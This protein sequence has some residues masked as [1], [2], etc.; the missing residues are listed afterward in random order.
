MD[1]QHLALLVAAG[2]GAG[3]CNALAGGGSLLT[4]PALLA[5]GMPPVAATVTNAVSVW[6]GYI[7]NA[8]ALR[9]HLTSFRPLLPRL[10]A[11]A[12]G[13]AVT[14]TV[15]LL[16]A[17]P[18]V[19][20]A[21]VPFLILSATALFACQPLITRR[22]AAS[23]GTS[24]PLL[25][26]GVFVGG[27]YGAYFN[28]GMGIVFLTALALGL[29]AAIGRLNGL[30]ALLTLT[31]GTTAM[32]SVALFGPVQWPAVLVLAPACLLGG[33]AGAKLADRLKPAAFRVLV[34]AFGT[35]AGTA[36]LLT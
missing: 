30:K 17:P 9:S 27:A 24:A 14:G 18:E 26:C 25:Y 16:A 5:I 33:F 11:L 1:P 21:L 36:M 31:A 19:F 32:V 15:A 20:T 4:F 3:V 23:G 8:V 12:A 22:L 28:G 7:G 2:L 35:A 6:P 29:D 34:I 13:G 10:V